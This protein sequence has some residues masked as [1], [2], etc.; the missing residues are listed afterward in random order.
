MAKSKDCAERERLLLTLRGGPQTGATQK[1]AQKVLN[2]T[3]MQKDSQ[4]QGAAGARKGSPPPE[5]GA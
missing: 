3:R 5:A 2:S 1:G 4:G